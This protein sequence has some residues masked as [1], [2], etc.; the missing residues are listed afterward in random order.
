MK[1]LVLGALLLIQATSGGADDFGQRLG[2]FHLHY[3]RFVRAYLGC[4]QGAREVEECDKAL[5]SF[6]YSEFNAARREARNIF[7]D[8]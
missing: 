8:R 3:S 7:T 4:P 2:R 5:G 6:D 1:R